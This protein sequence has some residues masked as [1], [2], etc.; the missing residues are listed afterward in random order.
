[1]QAANALFGKDLLGGECLDLA[2]PSADLSADCGTLGGLG[3]K[4]RPPDGV[5]DDVRSLLGQHVPGVGKVH[6]RGAGN[7]SGQLLGV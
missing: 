1:M 6:M 3:C 4:R 7:P 5:I 2:R